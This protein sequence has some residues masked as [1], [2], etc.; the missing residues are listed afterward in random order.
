MFNN[1]GKKKEKEKTEKR[2]KNKKGLLFLPQGWIL[3]RLSR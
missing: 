2:K 1:S 3:S